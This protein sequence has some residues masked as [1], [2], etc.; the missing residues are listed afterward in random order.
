[1]PDAISDVE[2]NSSGRRPT[3][4]TRLTDTSVI[5]ICHFFHSISSFAVHSLRDQREMVKNVFFAV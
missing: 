4:S 3:R 1:M 5:T 2:P